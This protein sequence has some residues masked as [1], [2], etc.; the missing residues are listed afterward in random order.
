VATG[1]PFEP[2]AL[3][4]R[5]VRIGQGNNA[6][7]FPG[8]GL[9]VLA[10]GI[11]RVTDGLFH[12]AA[13][14]LAGSLTSADLESG[15]LFPPVGRLRSVS[16]AVAAAVIQRAVQDGLCAALDAR[17]IDACLREHAWQA[18]YRPYRPKGPQAA[19]GG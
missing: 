4:G 8:V 7:I 10:A 11:R 9:A 16:A 6:F 18:E 14:A 2:V 3:D 1:S 13:Q 19:S 17:Q 5:T 12:A 15:L